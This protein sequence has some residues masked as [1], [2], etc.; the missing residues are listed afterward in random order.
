[1]TRGPPAAVAGSTM[2][3]RRPSRPSGSVAGLLIRRSA[4]DLRPIPSQ[5]R[6][7]DSADCRP[8]FLGLGLGVFP[9][10][11]RD[12][13]VADLRLAGCGARHALMV[14]RVPTGIHTDL[15]GS[16]CGVGI[17]TVKCTHIK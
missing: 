17:A 12:A 11:V 7:D 16:G 13:D 4:A 1:M 3:A 10:R 14:A 6:N 8:V 15:L 5:V 2:T 9:Y